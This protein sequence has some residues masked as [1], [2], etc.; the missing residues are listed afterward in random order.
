MIR[1]ANHGQLVDRN[2]A[3]KPLGIHFAVPEISTSSQ[4]DSAL[5][6]DEPTPCRPPDTL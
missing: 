2:P 3:F 1:I 5:T 6:T 4:L